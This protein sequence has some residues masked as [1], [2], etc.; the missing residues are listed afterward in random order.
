M[1]KLKKKLSNKLDR[2]VFEIDV[3]GD[4]QRIP[5]LFDTGADIPVFTYGQEMLLLY[6]PNA[7][8]QENFYAEIGG[9]GKIAEPAFIY[10]I[11]NFTIRSD[12]DQDYIQYYNLFIACIDKESIKYPFIL[13]ATM[14]KHMN[15]YV[16]NLKQD[17]REL[18]IYH[19]RMIYG[20][21]INTIYTHEKRKFIKYN[22]YIIDTMVH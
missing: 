20:T 17:N 6:Y 12:D 22:S 16:D 1:E 15:Y 18:T 7:I 13:S 14:F 8:L 5:C 10:N 4:R 2:P 9:F 11:P 21:G 19:N 3:Q